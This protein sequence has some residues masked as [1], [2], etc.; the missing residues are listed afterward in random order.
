MNPL[1]AVLLT[2]LMILSSPALAAHPDAPSKQVGTLTC[3]ILPHT[4]I[5]LLIHSTRDIRCE[6]KSTS[7]GAVERY[8]GETG[9]GFGLDVTFKKGSVLVYSVLADHF[10]QNTNQLAGKYSG[11]R[12]SVTTFGA[13]VGDIAPIEKDD[14]TVSLQPIRVRNKGVGAT[15]GF[16]YIYLEPDSD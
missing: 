5:N 2:S 13:T 9:I 14:G 6:F 15:L 16:T 3:T 12:G 10:K 4:G 11:A 1:S 8:K 7:E